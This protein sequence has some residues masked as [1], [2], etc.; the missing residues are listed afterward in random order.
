MKEDTSSNQRRTV[1]AK[2]LPFQNSYSRI[3]L[4]LRESERVIDLKEFRFA[5][6]SAIRAVHGDIAN[7]V[8][9]IDF[10]PFDS[11]NYSAIIRFKTVHHTRIIT[12][13]LLYGSFNNTDCRFDIVKVAPS[14]CCL[15]V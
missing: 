10:K 9:I 15:S 13:L 6:A 5:V 7:Q 11:S 1:A 8:D 2:I 3:K 12:S 14:L 4:T